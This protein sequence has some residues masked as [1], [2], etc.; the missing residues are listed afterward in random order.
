M[1]CA[2]IPLFLVPVHWRAV[3]GTYVSKR[4]YSVDSTDLEFFFA[5]KNFRLEVHEGC[6]HIPGAIFPGL[7]CQFFLF[8]RG[9]G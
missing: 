3:F 7:P 5:R 4:I 2:E 6:E 8:K 1:Q 9:F